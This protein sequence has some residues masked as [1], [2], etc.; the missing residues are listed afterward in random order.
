MC[1]EPS[2]PLARPFSLVLDTDYDTFNCPQWLVA[3]QN[4]VVSISGLLDAPFSFC[5]YTRGSVL[6]SMTTPTN[7]VAGVDAIINGISTGQLVGG[8]RARA[9][10]TTSGNSITAPASSDN[11]IIWIILGVSGAILLLIIIV[12]I[13]I[14]YRRRSASSSSSSGS[15]KGYNHLSD[16][17]LHAADYVAFDPVAGTKSASSSRHSMSSSQ[18]AAAPT[19]SNRVTVKI[20]HSVEKTEDTI[21]AA[22][23]GDIGFI[24]TEDWETRGDW[25][26]CTIGANQGYVPVGFCMI[27]IPK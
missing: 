8:V 4:Q 18:S 1:C 14:V 20:T 23:A 3:F 5:S 13:L 17:S 6:L 22:R 16:Q 9:G 19:R 25:V 7:A 10:T 2:G 21:L 15:R 27:Q 11:T 12:I 26:W 24:E